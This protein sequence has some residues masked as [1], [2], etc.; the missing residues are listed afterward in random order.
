VSDANADW[1]LHAPTK[2]TVTV[3]GGSIALPFLSRTRTQTIAGDPGTQLGSYLAATVTI[4]AS[5]LQSAQSDDFAFPPPM[6]P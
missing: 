4:P 2:Q 3:H 1:W 5:T 6:S